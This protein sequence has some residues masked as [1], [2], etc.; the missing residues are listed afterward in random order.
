LILTTIVLV[1]VTNLATYSLATGTIPWTGIRWGTG[2]FNVGTLQ[3]SARLRDV[4][5]LLL[6]RYIEP[7]DGHDLIE[8]ALKGMAEAVGDPYT[9]YMDPQAY[10]EWDIT[11]VGEYVGV[12]MVV[13]QIGDYVTVVSPMRGSP[14]ERA[15]LRPKDRIV[16]VDGKDVTRVPSEIVAALIRGE[17]GT[18]VTLTIA[19][20]PEEDEERFDVTLTRELIILESA[21]SVMLYPSEGIGYLQITDFSR[22]TVE[23]FDAAL[24]DLRSRGLKA[25]VLDLR[26][27][28]G[29]LLDVCTTLAG[30][31]VGEGVILQR[32]GR[33]GNPNV[34][35]GSGKEP[36]G[37]PLVV[38]VNEGSASASE[39]LA[40][41]IQDNGVGTLVGTVTFGKGLIMTPYELG[42]GSVLTVTTE[43]W[44]TPNGEHITNKG[45]TPDVVVELPEVGLDEEPLSWDDPDDPRDT[46]LR[47]ALEILRDALAQGNEG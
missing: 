27:N 35:S 10:E 43:R 29:G 22:K 15:G 33:D 46:Q 42:G 44:L 7:V 38:L 2:Q 47:R 14:A 8:G 26:N 20:G 16:A 21:R 6:T 19:R 18:Q 25:L 11:L 13:E 30:N 17:K 37:V 45:I 4:Y 9:F 24:A 12:G 28:G 31:F 36:L 41:A 1:L 32:I 39:I 40:G 3:D 23:Q 34:V 5:Q